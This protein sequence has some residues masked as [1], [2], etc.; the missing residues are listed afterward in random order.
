MKN[1]VEDPCLPTTP[2]HE[3]NFFMAMYVSHLIGGETLLSK[4]I[5]AGTIRGYL[6]EAAALCEPRGI[7]NPLIGIDGKKSPW[8]EDMIAEHKRWEQMP[9]RQEP[10]TLEMLKY[11]NKLAKKEPKDSL[12]ASMRDWL[13]LGNYAGFRLQEWAQEKKNTKNG[14]FAV[15]EKSEGGDGS[16]KAFLCEDFTFFGKRSKVITSSAKKVIH[17]KDTETMKLRYRYQKNGDNGQKVAY[18]KNPENPDFCPIVAGTNIRKRA[19]RLGVEKD[20][21]IAVYKNDKGSYSHITEKD[22]ERILQMAAKEVHNITNRRDLMR[23][24]SHSIRVGAAV[25]LHICGKDGEY[26]KLR[27]RWRS[28]TFR[29]YLRNADIMLISGIKETI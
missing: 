24:S 16:A 23:F 6:K 5:K 12:L 25:T 3:R 8:I 27:L 17:A 2:Q 20:T 29:L 18:A 13:C 7:M 4:V 14:G 1:F 26:I 19:Q 28:D 11:I 9:N 15:W 22:I 21:P 10:V